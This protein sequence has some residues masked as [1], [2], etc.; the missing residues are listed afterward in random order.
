MNDFVLCARNVSGGAFG[1]EN[2][3]SKFLLVPDG[4]QPN[5][6]QN[7][8]RTVWAKEVIK[9]AQSIKPDESGAV[10]H[11]LI[12]IHGYNN[13]Q[14]T[15]MERH[16]KLKKDLRNIGYNGTV[17]SF[18]WPSADSGLN[19]LEDRVDA[20][21]AAL[22]LVSDGIALFLQFLQPDCRI[23]IHLLAH[24]MGALVV[25][26]AFDDA[27]DRQAMANMNWKINQLLLIA[28]DI[29]SGSLS[30]DNST[31]DSLYRHSVRVTNYFNLHDS[32]LVLSN[33]K[34]VGI[35]PRAGRVGLPANRPAHAVEVNCSDYWKTIPDT[36]AVIG[37]RTHSWHIGDPV[38]TQD[39]LE[40]MWG[41]ARDEVSTR[42]GEGSSLTLVQPE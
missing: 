10:G 33:V 13:S 27:D 36:Q 35:A 17:V 8:K 18:D 5:P 42:E 11:I 30:A 32:V 38:F 6:T 22:Q 1:N 2:G 3:A 24:S 28:A 14:A 23:G 20:K 15:V 12:F 4:Q 26:E 39:I 7:V 34:R 25:R 41:V 40:T 29:S 9:E 37:N 21:Q 19:Y 16:R 31:T